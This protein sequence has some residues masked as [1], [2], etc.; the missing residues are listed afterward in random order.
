M[1]MIETTT[2]RSTPARSPAACRLRA[3]A[4]KKSVA[5]ASSGDGPVAASMS[6]DAGE[7]GVEPV[8]G[9]HVDAGRPGHR[10]RLV[11][12]LAQELDDV[13]PTRPV[14]PATAILRCMMC[15]LIVVL[16]G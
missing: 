9:D 3:A 16:K 6:V 2:I 1:P 7:R 10:D 4:V 12:A 14:P 8:A 5:S 13:R 15:L 11:A